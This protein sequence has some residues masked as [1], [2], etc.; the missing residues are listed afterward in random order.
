MWQPID[1]NPKD[2]EPFLGAI[3][4]G[5]GNWE[6]LRMKWN[7]VTNNFCDA[8]YEPFPEDREQPCKW[9]PLPDPRD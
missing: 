1:T 9:M 5:D 7:D 2:G 4:Y 8:T 6:V 3:D